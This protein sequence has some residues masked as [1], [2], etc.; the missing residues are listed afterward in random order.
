MIFRRDQFAMITLLKLLG[1]ADETRSSAPSI[2]LAE[3]P[4]SPPE[5]QVI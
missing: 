4:K 3:H 5:E 1:N 2:G